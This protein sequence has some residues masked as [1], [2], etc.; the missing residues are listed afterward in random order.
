MLPPADLPVSVAEIESAYKDSLQPTLIGLHL[1]PPQVFATTA[2][3]VRKS[4][5]RPETLLAPCF[6]DCKRRAS[7]TRY[8][9]VRRVEIETAR[10]SIEVLGAK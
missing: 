10:E 1:A 5:K 8:R 6:P 4:A 7:V 9:P 2:S 3:G